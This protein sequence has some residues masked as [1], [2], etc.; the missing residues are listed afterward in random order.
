ML[1]NKVHYSFFLPFYYYCSLCLLGTQCMS[2][3]FL[4]V[5]CCTLPYL[6]VILNPCQRNGCFQLGKLPLFISLTV[7]YLHQLHVTL[8]LIAR[9]TPPPSALFVSH[10]ASLGYHPRRMQVYVGPTVTNMSKTEKFLPLLLPVRLYFLRKRMMR[11]RFKDILCTCP[12]AD[13]S[14]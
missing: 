14:Q 8:L 3:L 10:A 12:C 1:Q 7:S 11:L 4:G 2:E 5:S 6:L 9:F 13:E